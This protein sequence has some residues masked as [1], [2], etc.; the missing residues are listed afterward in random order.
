M[1][2]IAGRAVARAFTA[3]GQDVP[4]AL[5]SLAMPE[6][7]AVTRAKDDWRGLDLGAAYRKARDRLQPGNKTETVQGKPYE[8]LADLEQALKHLL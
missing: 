8:T 4:R 2:G 1:S 5:Q 6:I 7:T 3:A